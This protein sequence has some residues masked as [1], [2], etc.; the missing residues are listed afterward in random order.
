MNW[1][2]K[3][4][5]GSGGWRSRLE[6]ELLPWALEGVPLG[7]DVLEIGPGPGATTDLLRGRTLRLTALE[8][9][10]T[11]AAA[12][13]KRLEGSGVRVIHGDGAA[14]PFEDCSFSCVV[15]LTMLHHVPTA[16]LQDR[17]MAEARRVLRPGGIFA[18]FDGV[19]SFLFRL[20]HLGDTY[21]PVNPGTLG[22]R[23]EAAGFTDVAV[24]RTRTR[25][26]FRASQGYSSA[27]NIP[28]S[29]CTGQESAERVAAG[30]SGFRACV[31]KP[32][33]RSS[34]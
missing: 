33:A 5:C 24:E 3:Q 9:D 30:D 29:D 2:H 6:R 18:G 10:A 27:D 13:Q 26:R 15:S 17:L 25:F 22:R 1:F 20:V 21:T 32:G 8:V 11:S 14:M 23:L 34:P 12:L 31:F 4:V 19:G 28:S 16:A 7:D